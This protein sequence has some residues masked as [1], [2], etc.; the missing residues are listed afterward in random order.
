MVGTKEFF[1]I[2]VKLSPP[3]YANIIGIFTGGIASPGRTRDRWYSA[4]QFTRHTV[5]DNPL[6]IGQIGEPVVE[7]RP[8]SAVNS[9]D[10]RG[11]NDRL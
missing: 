6:Q 7:E 3:V 5:V 8:S 9:E 1:G 2:A 10:Y 11:D 4:L